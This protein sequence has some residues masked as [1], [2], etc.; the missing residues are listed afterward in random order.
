MCSSVCSIYNSEK[1]TAIAF[2]TT[3][4]SIGIYDIFKFFSTS[5]TFGNGNE[6]GGI[7]LSGLVFLI[8]GWMEHIVGPT[9]SYSVQNSGRD[10][11]TSRTHG[12]T[13]RDDRSNTQIRMNESA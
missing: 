5:S 3:E 9:R 10:P 7:F 8:T 13:H 11:L 6:A 2:Q 4:L 12:H 1:R